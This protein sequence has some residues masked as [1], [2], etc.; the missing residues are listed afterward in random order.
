[1]NPL[2]LTILVALS[3]T[4]ASGTADAQAS[5]TS[6]P[7]PRP[8]YST[9]GP[10]LV[11][12]LG[13]SF[14]TRDPFDSSFAIGGG[15]GFRFTPAFRTDLTLTYRPDLGGDLSNWTGMLNFYYDLNTV[16][17]ADFVPYVKGGIGIAENMAGG[18]TFSRSGTGIS[19]VFGNQA[20]LAW[21]V[22]GGLSYA[23]SDHT[24]VDLDYQYIQMG[25]TFSSHSSGLRL[26]GN[27]RAHEVKVGF[28]YGF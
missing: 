25:N 12:Q 10:Y 18:T 19:N 26:S 22:G 24:A 16:H 6:A 1:M 21:D 23:L 9:T 20:Q 8:V 3:T 14:P 17:L 11:G 4:A 27:L 5:A 15:L 13:G 7:S 28:R 2:K